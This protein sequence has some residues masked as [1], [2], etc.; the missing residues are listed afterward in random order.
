MF[1]RWFGKS[2]AQC[3]ET[4]RQSIVPN[5]LY[6]STLKK[7]L[8]HPQPALSEGL[9]EL[10]FVALDFEMSGLE[11]KKDKILSIG[12]VHLNCNEINLYSSHEIYLDH[13]A[14]V[15]KESAEVNEIVPQQ[16]VNAT[17]PKAALDELLAHLEGKVVVAHSAC[18]ERNFLN[19]LMRTVNGLEHLPCHF[20][21]TL[22]IEKKY[23][24]AGSSKSHHSYQL[25][26]LRRHYNL[27]DYYA[28][29]AASDAFACA[30]LFLVQL[31][32]L[33][34]KSECKISDV[35]I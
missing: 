19:A 15:K 3:Q 28:H 13:G 35:V 14:Y 26:D 34:L 22:Q 6:S 11:A 9:T 25:N 16:L 10:Q 12:L 18:I 31:S 2:S 23:S 30:E 27:P 29:S 1:K 7:Y 20:I 24:Y 32:K 33:K 5:T 8:Q 21:D 4:L 17:K